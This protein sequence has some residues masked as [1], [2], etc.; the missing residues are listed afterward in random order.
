MIGRGDG[1]LTAAVALFAT[2]WL[3]EL[4]Q[5]ARKPDL[6]PNHAVCS[7][8]QSFL[9]GDRTRMRWGWLANDLHRF[10]LGFLTQS[11][12]S[13]GISHFL[14]KFMLVRTSIDAAGRIV[15]PKKLRERYGLG[16]GSTVSIIPL[17]DGISI[18]TGHGVAPL[19]DFDV[20]RVRDAQLGGT[21][22]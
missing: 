2:S 14:W 1:L 18:V 20:D 22:S 8:L 21:M 11:A 9:M 4:H 13:I 6:V 5:P 12:I 15:I 19:S 3:A 10:S 17:P 16:T 7:G